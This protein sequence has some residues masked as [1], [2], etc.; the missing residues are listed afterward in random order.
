[1]KRMRKVFIEYTD[2]NLNLWIQTARFQRD[3]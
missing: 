3:L 1:M 2:N